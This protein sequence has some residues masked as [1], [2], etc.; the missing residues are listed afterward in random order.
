MR[1]L[2]ILSTIWQ[3]R[4]RRWAAVVTLTAALLLTGC[5]EAGQM[6]EQPRYDPLEPSELFAD[7]RSA[8]PF[9]PGTVLY[10]GDESPNRPELTGLNEND[11]PV[12]GFPVEVNAELLEKGQERYSIYCTPCHGQTGEGNGRVTGFGYPK[13]PSLLEANAKSLTTGKVFDIITNGQ[14]NMYPYAYRIKPE[15]RWAVIAYMRAMQLKN[16]APNLQEL[17]PAEL[18]Q[19]GM[20]P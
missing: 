17:T 15:E 19:I 2:H 13:P 12:T 5:A 20:Q 1:S 3:V 8:R 9:I 6:I 4:S 16:G 11:E 18:E 10:S 7:G 14:G